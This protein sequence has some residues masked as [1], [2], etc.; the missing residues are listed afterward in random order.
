MIFNQL[1]SLK[2]P[3]RLPWFKQHQLSWWLE[4]QTIK[5]QCTYYFGPF[6]SKREAEQARLDYTYE[7]YMEQATGFSFNISQTQPKQLTI[8]AE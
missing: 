8:S 5:P 7:L 3:F 6:N 4:I 1:T 2:L